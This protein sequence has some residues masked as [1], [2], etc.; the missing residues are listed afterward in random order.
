MPYPQAMDN[1]QYHNAD[2]FEQV[3]GGWVMAQDGF[4][5]AA[6][7]ARLEAFLNTPDV[8]SKAAEN[9]KSLGMYDA[10][11]KLADLVLSRAATE[12]WSGAGERKMPSVDPLSLT[13]HHSEVAA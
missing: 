6:L 12:K 4:T 13:T 9:A 1:H 10:A 2:A 11:E 8:L 7:A 5:P 3:G